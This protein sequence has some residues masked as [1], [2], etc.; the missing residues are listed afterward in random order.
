M[1]LTAQ[2]R[3][4]ADV[5]CE[6]RLAHLAFT[7][8][9]VKV[10]FWG[11][12][13]KIMSATCSSG[14]RLSAATVQMLFQVPHQTLIVRLELR[15]LVGSLNQRC[16]SFHQHPWNRTTNSKKTSLIKA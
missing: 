16:T 13:R 7:G 3:I 4:C 6:S 8:Y 10:V 15:A 11:A 14:F 1:K 12:G 9:Y 5:L 2:E